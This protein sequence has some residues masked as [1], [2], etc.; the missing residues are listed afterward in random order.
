[1]VR[2]EWPPFAKNRGPGFW[3]NPANIAK[4]RRKVLRADHSNLW[5]YAHETA[6]PP[7]QDRSVPFDTVIP[8]LPRRFRIAIIGD[9]G[10]GDASQYALVPLLRAA[11]PDFMIIN[12]DVAYPAGD[13]DDFTEGFFRPY[14]GFG[15]PIWATAGNHEY[16][17]QHK[18]KEFYDVFCGLTG[19]LWAHYGLRMVPQPGM[20][21]ELRD[22]SGRTPLVILGLDSGQ[23]ANLDGH[24]TFLSKLLSG[25]KKPDSGQ[26]EWLDWRLSVADAAG[27]KVIVMFHIPGLVKGKADQVHLGEV[28][29]ILARHPSVRAVICGHIHNHERYEPATFRRYLAEQYGVQAN[30]GFPPP[31]Y[32][33]SGNGGATLD[34]TDFTGAYDPRDV[35]PSVGQW[36]EYASSMRRMLNSGGGGGIVARL[37]GQFERGGLPDY[38]DPPKLQSFLLLDVDGP[39]IKLCHIVLDDLQAL[40]SKQPEGTIV[41]VDAPVPPMDPEALQDL[42]TREL[43][44][45]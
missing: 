32:I 20:Y 36:K 42:C 9:T 2:F 13:M 16:Y 14:R 17:S 34:G 1:M 28:H 19:A 38:G 33:V 41:R 43:F 23:D 30:P 18:G 10:E 6:N 4:S 31:E 40:Y 21:W 45:L 15:I 7:R 5:R 35:Y 26:H 22:P 12:G 11:K 44:S 39:Q 24:D 8:G 3:F 37:A 25:E 27:G 29:R